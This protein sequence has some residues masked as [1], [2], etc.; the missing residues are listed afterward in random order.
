[1][2]KIIAIGPREQDIVYTNNLFSGSITLYGSNQHSNISYSSIRQKRINHNVFTKEQGEFIEQ[3]MLKKIAEDPSV[4]FMSYD[5][6]QAYDCN[7]EIVKRTVCLNPKDIMDKLNNKISFRNWA[8]NFCRIHRSDLLTGD[9]CS[10]ENLIEQYKTYDTFVIQQYLSTGGEGTFIMSK[11]NHKIVE[12]NLIA[13]E[14]YL[15]SGYEKYNIPVNMHAIIYEEEILLFPPSIQIMQ[16]SDNK[17]LYRG[18]DFIAIEQ[19]KKDILDEFKKFM[20][21]ICHQLQKE[22]YRGI[23]GVDGMIVDGEVYI[24]EM[25]NRFQGSTQLINHSLKDYNLPSMHELNYRAFSCK[26]SNCVL[27]DFTVPYSCYTYIAD[28]YGNIP[29]GHKRMLNCIEAEALYDDGLSYDWEIA[30]YATL[31]R[32]VFKTNIVTITTSSTVKI[33]PNIPDMD[34]YWYNKIL[35]GEDFIYLKIALINQGVVLS[36]EAIKYFQEHGGY[37]KGVYNAID[38]FIN[39]LVINTPIS[40]KFVGL[41][42]FKII[43]HDNVLYLNCCMHTIAEVKI[44]P[45]DKLCEAY[46]ASGCQVK[47]TCFLATDRLRVQHSCNCD[48]VRHGIGCNFCEVENHEFSFSKSDIFESIDMYLKSEYAFRHFL[49]GGRSDSQNKDIEE[50]SAIANYIY[51]KGNWP[52]YVM[53]I[54]PREFKEI[55]RLFNSHVTEVAFNIEIWDRK[56]AKKWMPGKGSIPISRYLN[57]LEYAVSLWGNT[58]KVRTSFIVGLEPESSLM[59]GIKAVCRL[60]VAPILSVFRPI[61]GTE[62]AD[63]APP[64]NEELYHIYINASKICKKYGLSLGPTCIPCQ[65]NTL[66]MPK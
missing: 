7:D 54:P 35:S 11:G 26:K 55:D 52:I 59:E 40:T 61:P 46:T 12:K 29:F 36:D 17:L 16:L 13:N 9:K 21:S 53:C 47:D 5:P 20:M 28:K 6:N 63:V 44:Q 3:E 48:F 58:G 49:I 45:A 27:D 38:L 65:N 34:D 51:T 60:G 57:M 32:I 8:K 15:V 37:R 18:A 62:G 2:K 25:N 22:G 50:I 43:C 41:S 66:S 23:T 64:S 56:L 30:P 10:Y 24:L 39:D 31:E 42:P 19:I 4:Q 1:M 14:K 33:H